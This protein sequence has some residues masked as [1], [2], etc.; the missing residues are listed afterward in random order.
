MSDKTKTNG[1]PNLAGQI[2]EH[3]RSVKSPRERRTIAGL[4]RGLSH[5]PLD[6]ARAALDTSAAIAA[7]SLRASIEFLRAASDAAK[8]LEAAELRAW[9][10]MGRRLTIADVEGG[11]NFFASGVDDFAHVPAM[12]RPFVLQVCSRQMVLSAS[13][14]AQTFNEAPSLAVQVRDEKVLRAVY[15]IAGAIA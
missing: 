11:V 14:A 8:V 9:G 6:H 4:L 12:V 1:E 2:E 5:L 15:E 10:E 13:T 7:I 3:L